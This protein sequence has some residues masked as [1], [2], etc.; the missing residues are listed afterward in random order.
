MYNL[1]NKEGLKKFKELTSKDTFLSEVF[2]EGGKIETQTKIFLKR[3]NYCLSKCFDKIRITKSKQ[4]KELEELFTQRRILRN[5]KDEQSFNKLKL[6]EDKLASICANENAEVITEA[7]E[8][9]SCESGG[10][11]AGKLWG[12]KKKLQGTLQE[13][14]SAMIDK[15]GN[16]VTTSKALE[17]L[18]LEMYS[19]R[20]KPNKIK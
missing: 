2:S 17:E 13:P 7:Y 20:L 19:E 15:I 8:G 3:L 5:K 16:L 4:N 12:L 9:L 6:V 14:P 11:N 18:T 1:K 10:V